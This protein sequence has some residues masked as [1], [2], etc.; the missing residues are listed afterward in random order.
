ML[1]YFFKYYELPQKLPGG[2]Y[3]QAEL[4]VEQ[5]GHVVL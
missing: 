3:L 1:V 4:G 2:D 5:L